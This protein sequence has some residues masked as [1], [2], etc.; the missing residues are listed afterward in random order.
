MYI[1]IY[2]YPYI[3]KNI[4]KHIISQQIRNPGCVLVRGYVSQQFS[5]G[6]FI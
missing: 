2:I 5:P 4:D 6:L 1:C 3:P